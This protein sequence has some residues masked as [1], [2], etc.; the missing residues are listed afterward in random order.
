MNGD[1]VGIAGWRRSGSPG[2]TGVTSLTSSPHHPGTQYVQLAKHLQIFYI[3]TVY[4]W[5]YSPADV[6]LDSSYIVNRIYMY[7][8]LD[9]MRRWKYQ[10]SFKLS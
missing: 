3:S 7:V 9:A 4:R 8:K 6:S 5:P 2:S 1:T 10:Q